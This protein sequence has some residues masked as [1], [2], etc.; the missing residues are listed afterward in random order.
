MVSASENDYMGLA[1]EMTRFID[2][3]RFDEYSPELLSFL[4][5]VKE[6]KAFTV[7]NSEVSGGVSHG[8]V[9]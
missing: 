8:S 2:T 1:Y 5:Q 7:D 3:S 4:A 6:L 9:S